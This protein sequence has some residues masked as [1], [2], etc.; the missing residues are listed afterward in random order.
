MCPMQINVGA[1]N[2]RTMRRKGKLQNVKREMKRAQILGLSE[3]R[4]EG[5]GDEISG[6]YRVI[7][8]GGEKGQKGVAIIMDKTMSERVSKVIQ[9][10]D[11]L[12][13]IRIKAEPV[14]L[15]II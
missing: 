13:L 3:V 1:W 5:K 2:V 15:V 8:S 14:D 4:W 11:R 10:S 9:C 6:E 7:H 12:M